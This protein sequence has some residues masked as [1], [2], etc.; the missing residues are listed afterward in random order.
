MSRWA[1]IQHE[2]SEFARRV[3][4]RFDAGTNKMMATLR[5]DGSPRISAIELQIIDE[6][7]PLGMMGGSPK[8][9]DVRRD[10]RAAIDA[11]TIEPPP[12]GRGWAGDAKLAGRLVE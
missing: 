10:P 1:T 5:M 8:L 11:T 6:D 7:A 3:R 9:R 2:A 12:T 4:V